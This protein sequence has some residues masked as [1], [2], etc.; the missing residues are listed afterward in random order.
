MQDPN[1]IS[2]RDA[3]FS[4]RVR[5]LLLR[6]LNCKTLGDVVDLT[7]V[8]L[9]K[10]PNCGR[11]SVTNFKEVLAKHGFVRMPVSIQITK[12]MREAAQLFGMTDWEYARNMF[13]LIQE[14]IWGSGKAQ[15]LNATYRYVWQPPKENCNG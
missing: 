10:H 14:G 13:E 6:H 11:K 5:N 2:I 3:G 8:D 12:Q 7:E 9:L 4:C 1:T 15:H